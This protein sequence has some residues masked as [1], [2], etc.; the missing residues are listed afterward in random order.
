MTSQRLKEHIARQGCHKERNIYTTHVEGQLQVKVDVLWC[1]SPHREQE[2][3]PCFPTGL[4][5]QAQ[6]LKSKQ[7]CLPSEDSSWPFF[8]VEMRGLLGQLDRDA[9]QF[10]AQWPLW[11]QQMHEDDESSGG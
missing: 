11:L 8:Q 3:A 2:W 7:I 6:M 9:E 10:K 1:E 5:E 4:T